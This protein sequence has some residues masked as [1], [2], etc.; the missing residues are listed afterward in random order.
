MRYS[1][2][3]VIFKQLNIIVDSHKADY[4]K[5]Y[6]LAKNPNFLL[7]NYT[8]SLAFYTETEAV[9]FGTRETLIVL[10]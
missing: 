3:A 9:D 10:L 7:N 2:G 6:Q 1:G 8:M 5:L 4:V